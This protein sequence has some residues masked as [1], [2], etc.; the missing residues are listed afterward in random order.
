MRQLPIFPCGRPQS[1]FGASELNF[2]VRNEN[3][4][5]LTAIATA[6]VY[7]PFALCLS[8]FARSSPR[9]RINIFFSALQADN[10][11]VNYFFRLFPFFVLLQASACFLHNLFQYQ[12]VSLNCLRSSPRPISIGQLNALLRLHP[13]PI[14]LVVFKGSY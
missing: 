9:S 6:M 5:I 1:I 13:R 11:I 2:C 8:V 4:W 3:R 12:F 7:F 10:R 14:Y